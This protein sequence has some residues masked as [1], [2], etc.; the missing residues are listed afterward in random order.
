M[1][2]ELSSTVWHIPQASQFPYIL[3]HISFQV[4]HTSLPLSFVPSI[5]PSPSLSGMHMHWSMGRG[6][7]KETVE[8]LSIRCIIS[9]ELSSWALLLDYNSL[10]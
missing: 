1:V 9:T 6:Q 10:T 8:D 4:P 7:G 3:V 2:S 5:P